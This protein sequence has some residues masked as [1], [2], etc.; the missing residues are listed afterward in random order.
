MSTARCAQHNHYAIRWLKI[1]KSGT[2]SITKGLKVKKG[3]TKAI[4]TP[5]QD[6]FTIGGFRASRT[7][8]FENKLVTPRA[9]VTQEGTRGGEAHVRARVASFV[10]FHSET[11][12]VRWTCRWVGFGPSR[13]PRSHASGPSLTVVGGLLP[14]RC[15][16]GKLAASLQASP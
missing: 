15:S 10:L 13:R 5:V 8:E 16:R 2:I 4:K 3:N 9:A 1:K 6:G 11:D 14:M 7:S 12:S